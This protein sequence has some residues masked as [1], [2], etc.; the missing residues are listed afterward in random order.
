MNLAPKMSVHAVQL[1]LFSLLVC[2]PRGLGAWPFGVSDQNG[3]TKCVTCALVTGLVEQMSEIYNISIAESLSRFCKFLPTGL[4]EACVVLVDN[5]GPEVIEML[6][7]KETPDI[8]CLGIGM[9]TKA[10][11][12]VCHLFPL[13]STHAKERIEAAKKRAATA[14]GRVGFPDLCNI[15]VVKPICEIF[16]RFGND[17]FP[18]DD[19]DG[20]DFSDLHTFRGTSWR[21]K[22]CSDVDAAVHPGRHTTDDAFVDTNCNGI[23]GTN[24]NTGKTYESELCEGTGQMGTAVLGDSVGAHFHI[25]PQWVTSKDISVEAFQDILFILE[26]ELDW[27]MLSS[28]TAYTNSTWSGISGPVDSTYLRMRE[29]NRCNHRDYQN[30]AVN[31][32]RSG[33]MSEDI[34]QS[35]AR[36]KTDNPVFIVFELVGNDVCSGHPDID[37]MTTPQEFYANNLK[38]F[39]YLDA[40]IPPGSIVIA[41]GLVD[42]RILFDS[43]HDRIH[44]IGSY[45]NDVTYAAFYDY[46]NC[47]QISPCFGWMNTNETWRNVTT[48][49]AM[50]LNQALRDLVSNQTF[51]N[52]KIYYIDPPVQTAINQWVAQ[53]GEAWQLIEP[54]DGFHP[55]QIGNALT[56]ASFWELMQSTIPEVIPPVNPHNEEIAQLFGDQGGY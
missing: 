45:R 18:V 8:V 13:P 4:Q 6:E 32:A 55:N 9:C 49:R 46:L 40:Y 37:H 19:V 34:V 30:I 12:E 44:P 10:S 50:E 2:A 22:D 29:L 42:G 16:E 39:R 7:N 47:L 38:T 43:L 26:N 36:N 28:T 17:H 35:F 25:P 27:P 24:P 51:N 53:G 52:F 23:Y 54:V 41:N 3:G 1:A 20:D 5:Y 31:G 48:E 15:P 21:G 11:G 56:T 14:E 33:A